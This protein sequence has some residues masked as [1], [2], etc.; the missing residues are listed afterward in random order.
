MSETTTDTSVPRPWH[1]SDSPFEAL[2]DWMIAELD[3]IKTAANPTIKALEAR[4]AEL[5]TRPGPANAFASVRTPPPNAPVVAPPAE[6]GSPAIA[7]YVSP[8]APAVD[9]APQPPVPEP[10][11]S[12]EPAV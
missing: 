11:P 12:T 9:P 1:G 5:E 7:A 10:A 4:I 3:A 8:T 2:H 6:P